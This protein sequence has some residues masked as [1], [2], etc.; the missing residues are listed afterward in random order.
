M[1]LSEPVS[2]RGASERDGLRGRVVAAG[3][4]S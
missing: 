4:M 3:A 2:V 1:T